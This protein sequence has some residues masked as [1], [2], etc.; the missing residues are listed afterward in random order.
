MSDYTKKNMKLQTSNPKPISFVVRSA[1]KNQQ[2]PE[3]FQLPIFGKYLKGV[4]L[5]FPPRWQIYCSCS[6]QNK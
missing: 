6:Q 1:C 3:N 4:S 5:H 2:C